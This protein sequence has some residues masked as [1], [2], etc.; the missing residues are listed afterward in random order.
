MGDTLRFANE[1]GA[2]TLTDRGTFLA[3]QD[4]LPNLEV[5][6]GGDS[7]AGNADPSLLN[8]YGVI[9]VN[10]DK[11]NINE[12]LAQAFVTWLTEVETQESLSQFGTEKF[13]QPLFYPNSEAWN[14]R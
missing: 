14:S 9:P 4:S 7:I 3:M 6:V 1:S 13:G 8:P 12:A 11:G 10:P 5:L 2:Y